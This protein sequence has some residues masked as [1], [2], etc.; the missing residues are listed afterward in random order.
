MC[1]ILND[2]LTALKGVDKII[3][4]FDERLKLL[5]VRRVIDQ[6]NPFV[7]TF[8]GRFKTGKSS[9]INALCGR[10]MLPTRATTATAVV[11]RIVA[12]E[13]FG[14]KLTAFLQHD[15]RERPLTLEKAQDIIL[16][17]KSDGK[18]KPPEVVFRLPCR[19]LDRDVEIRDLPG[20][21][22]SAQDGRLEEVALNAIKDSDVCVLVYDAGAMLSEA[23][24][25]TTKRVHELLGGNVV[26]AVNCTNRLNNRAH[27]KQIEELSSTFFGSMEFHHSGMGKY[28][29]MCSAPNMIELGGFDVWLKKF[30]GLG[31]IQ[32]RSAIR[33]TV[34]NS[35]R[36]L[37]QREINEAASQLK[38]RLVSIEKD[39]RNFHENRLSTLRQKIKVENDEHLNAIKLNALD[40]QQ[41]F[42]STAGLEEELNKLKVGSDWRKDYREKSARATAEYF[43]GNGARLCRRWG[44][45]YIEADFDFIE[46]IFNRMNFPEPSWHKEK[47]TTG[48]AVGWGTAGAA[49]GTFFL[50]GLGTAIGGL[51]GASFGAQDVIVD[52][53]VSKTMNFVSTQLNPELRIGFNEMSNRKLE[54]QRRLGESKSTACSSGLEEI[55]D[56]LVRLQVKLSS[57]I[58]E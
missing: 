16:N 43:K 4:A 5:S 33:D 28:Y 27:F 10:D 14:K 11:T 53:S 57:Y 13:S 48:D 2:Q 46:S 19:W 1:E 32:L 35:K 42:C 55:L 23:E 41:L 3:C 7:I 34:D 15:G 54:E 51:L 44:D 29:M 24:R 25:A 21:G 9:L 12:A 30:A 50:P 39:V 58:V 38:E 37:G 18:R 45:F 47:A 20:M 49:I 56:K 40:A 17:Y 6:S 22:D 31:C 52:D 36:L 26:F 8:A